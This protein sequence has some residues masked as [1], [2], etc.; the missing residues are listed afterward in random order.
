MT[1]RFRIN[2]PNVLVMEICN[3]DIVCNL[4][5]VIWDFVPY[6]KKQTASLHSES[7]EADFGV[8]L[9]TPLLFLDMALSFCHIF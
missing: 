1:A 2:A 5:I 4:S 8:T 7:A 9:D 6:P 3:F